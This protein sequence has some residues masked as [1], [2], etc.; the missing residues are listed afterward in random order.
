MAWGIVEVFAL[1]YLFGDITSVVP[2]GGNDKP[3]GG[4]VLPV[5]Y[6]NIIALALVLTLSLYAVG[7]WKIETNRKTRTDLVFLGVLLVSGFSLWYTPYG[8]FPAIL[9]LVYFLAVNVE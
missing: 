1:K 3:I 2:L 8:L 9:S 5:L 6:F 7:I 4:S